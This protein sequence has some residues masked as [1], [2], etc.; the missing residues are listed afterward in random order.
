MGDHEQ[1]FYPGEIKD[2]VISTLSKGLEHYPLRSRRHDV[3]ND[4]IQSNDFQG[5][6]KQRAAEADRLLKSYSRMTA[7]IQKGLEDLGFVFYDEGKHYKAKYY[8]D[9]RYIVMH[10]KTPSDHRTE[11]I[12]HRRQRKW[13][14]DD[15]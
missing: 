5:I 4:V 7:K 12:M 15:R 9:D 8:D 3:V 2:L 11:K 10:A 1:D 6:S 14:F 13:H